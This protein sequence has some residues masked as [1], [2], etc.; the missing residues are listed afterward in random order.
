MT[1][2][3]NIQQTDDPFVD[4]RTA[5]SVLGL[6]PRTLQK[7]RVV[8][9]GPRYSKLGPKSVRYRLSEVNAWADARV[10]NSTSEYA[11]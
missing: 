4:E 10:K 2:Q 3:T 5:A 7:Y 6:S 8:G 1:K 11:A 9:G